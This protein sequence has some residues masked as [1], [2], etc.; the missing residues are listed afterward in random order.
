MH[1]LISYFITNW[2]EVPYFWR[3][4]KNQEEFIG[5]LQSKLDKNDA[6]A[7]VSCYGSV[8]GERKNSYSDSFHLLWECQEASSTCILPPT[9]ALCVRT[10]RQVHP[11][12]TIKLWS[13]TLDEDSLSNT[14]QGLDIQLTRYDISY[15]DD[16]PQAAQKGTFHVSLYFRF[17]VLSC[18]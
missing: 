11:D 16:L 4:V 15:F 9:H 18:C 7:S 10:L 3:T 2:V 5:K 6:M 1:V 14:L 13:T 17:C 12:A 8:K